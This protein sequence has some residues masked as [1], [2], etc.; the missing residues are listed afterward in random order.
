MPATFRLDHVVIRVRDLEQA[1]ADYR[2]LGFTVTPGGEHP[3]LGS[4]NALIPFQDDT[5]LELIA[6]KPRS[7]TE[8]VPESAV[9]RRWRRWEECDEGLVDFALVPSSAEEAIRE[10]RERGL[11]ID[12][13]FPG[14]RRRP[15]GQEV[16]W[17]LGIPEAFEAPFLCADVTPRELRVPGGEARRHANGVIGIRAVGTKALDFDATIERY[18]AL[19]GIA[20]F[21]HLKEPRI[22]AIRLPGSQI[23]LSS[24]GPCLTLRASYITDEMLFDEK[25]AH[26]VTIIRL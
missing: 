13:P 9:T 5:Y 16:A 11:A 2:E 6:F 25:Q 15:D 17:Q 8:N 21:L 7:A 10:A 20:P 26:G 24:R 3:T 22:A 18:R 19:L 1:C 12:G 23:D 14:S 4:R